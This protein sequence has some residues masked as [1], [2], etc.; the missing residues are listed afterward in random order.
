MNGS[1]KYPRLYISAKTHKRVHKA[2]KKEKE[3]MKKFGEKVAIA[4]LRALGY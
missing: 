4:G 3:T 2:S 1:I